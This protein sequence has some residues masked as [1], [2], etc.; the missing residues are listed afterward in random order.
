MIKKT[1]CGYCKSKIKEEAKSCRKCK[2]VFHLRKERKN[3]SYWEIILIAFILGSI[4][5]IPFGML[6]GQIDNEICPRKHCIT[7]LVFPFAEG[8]HDA[9]MGSLPVY[10]LYG[11]FLG[12][13]VGIPIAIT[14]YLM[15]RNKK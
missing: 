8:L 13:L 7:N 6:M 14:I 1:H 9:G 11:G 15:K 10:I 2:K 4:L 12:L 5:I 3:L